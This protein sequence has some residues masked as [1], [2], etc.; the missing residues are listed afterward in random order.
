MARDLLLP[1]PFVDA[2]SASRGASPGKLSDFLRSFFGS[3]PAQSE[4][5]RFIMANGGVLTDTLER[6][7][8]RRF[9]R[10]VE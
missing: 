5:E 1:S 2:F 9:G 4:V 6:E 8:S 10:V 7:I 3:K